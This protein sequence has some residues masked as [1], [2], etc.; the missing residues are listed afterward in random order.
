LAIHDPGGDYGTGLAP[1]GSDPRAAARRALGDGLAAAGRTGEAPDLV[2]VTAT[3]GAEEEIIAGIQEV[4][5]PHTPVVG[6]S[7]AD[8][9]VAGRWRVLAGEHAMDDAVAVSALFPSVPVSLAFQNGYAPTRHEGLATHVDGRRLVAIDG[10]PAADVYAAWAGEPDWLRPGNATR[11]ILADST[12]LP[13]GRPISS[14]SGVP[15]YL[16][17]HPAAVHPCGAL[18]LFANLKEGE[19]IC[20]MEGSPDSLTARAG[21]VARQAVVNSVAGA[22]ISGALVVYCGG[23]MLAV[24]D[25]VAEL[26]DGVSQ[27]L[28]GAPFLGVFTFGEQGLVTDGSNRHGNLMVSCVVFGC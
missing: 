3:P 4:V 10:R 11:S 6:G 1:K 24:E 25:R 26:S 2:W 19:P 20:L 15:Y 7:A 9:A 14:L 23:C 13:L 16:L 17:A 28:G 21:R 27:A 22:A 8:D 18:D 5:G 12:F